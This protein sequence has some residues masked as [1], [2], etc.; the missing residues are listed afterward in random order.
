MAA[1]HAASAARS[2]HEVSSHDYHH[3]SMSDDSSHKTWQRPKAVLPVT[4]PVIGGH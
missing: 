1:L 4:R 3:V 2:E